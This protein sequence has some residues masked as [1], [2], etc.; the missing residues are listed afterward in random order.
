LK[1][2]GWK[3]LPIARKIAL[4]LDMFY[5]QFK[6]P[7]DA[8]A[9]HL[10]VDMPSRIARRLVVPALPLFMQR[11]PALV[12]RLSSCDRFVDLVEDA[13]DCV[14]RVGEPQG[15]NLVV[16]ALGS[17]DMVNCASPG[18]LEQHG[19]P[20]CP[21][22]LSRHWVVGYA[23]APEM[24]APGQW[25]WLDAL[26]GR[27]QIQMPY[28]LVVNNVENYLASCQA[29]MGLIQVPRFDV[30]DLLASGALIEVLCDWAAPPMPVSALYLP[31]R[32]D[33]QPLLAFINWFQSLLPL[34][35]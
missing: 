22:D 23:P 16:R 27:H 9:G 31:R 7:Q 10:N 17:V 15:Y 12:L 33:S 13:V 2:D 35:A 5:E 20:Q 18:Y 4:D 24:Q 14:I 3:T 11:Y 8:F 32:Q 29:D 6:R 25:Q 28:R 19:V 34:P 30:R 21:D 26:G 1:E